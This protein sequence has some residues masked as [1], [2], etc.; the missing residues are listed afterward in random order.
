MKIESLSYVSIETNDLQE[1]NDYAQ[2]VVGLMKNELLSD[3]H[4]LFLRMDE[5]AFRFH[6][7]TGD[8][9]KFIAA[10]LNIRDKEEFEAA[11][12]ELTSANVEFENFSDELIAA[13]C[14]ENG[15]ALKDPAGNVLEIS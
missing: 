9:K 7:Q 13:R 14:V 2:N 3:D 10:G 6:I 15:I 5:K 1:W 4:N 11:K 12:N 8:S